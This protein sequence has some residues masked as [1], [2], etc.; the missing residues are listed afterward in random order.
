MTGK[1]ADVLPQPRREK[2]PSRPR[3]PVVLPAI[4][5]VEG[6]A[7]AGLAGLDGS[8]AWRVARGPGGGAGPAPARG[9]APRASRPPG[10]LGTGPA[11]RYGLTY[12]DV[13]FR[14]ADGVRLSA[15]YLPSRN[16]AAVVLLPGSGSTRTA[17]LSQA[18]VLARHGYGALLVDTRGH[19]L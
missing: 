6:V 16:S 13:S 7:F 10:P 19:G 17:V 5:T 14:T 12:Q 11:A 8:P 1:H 18:A 9:V 4:V 2:V 15:W 3:A